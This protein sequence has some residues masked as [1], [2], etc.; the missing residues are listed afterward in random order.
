[1]AL[2]QPNYNLEE[3]R[4]IHISQGRPEKIAMQPNEASCIESYLKRDDV[5]FE[6]GSGWSTLHFSK[7][8]DRFYSVEHNQGW[9]N[10]VNKQLK[11]GHIFNTKLF[12]IPQLP[13]VDGW[14]DIYYDKNLDEKAKE[15][16]L[17]YT[18][19]CPVK[20]LHHNLGTLDEVKEKNGK[21]YWE[22]RG[23]GEWHQY[24]DYINSIEQAHDMLL[25][26]GKNKYKFDKV[27]V[28]G[29]CRVFCAY[30]AL[31]FIDENS[32]VFMHDFVYRPWYQTILKW[33]KVVEI[34][35]TLVVLRRK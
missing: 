33:Y 27:L 23:G 31:E 25:N 18:P 35:D 7:F 29:R 16:L 28:D 11:E 8:V 5:M 9:S 15:L 17:H 21:C 12:T 24:I 4:K 22:P 6:Y 14:E 3:A 26:T 34:I 30:K 20:E 10:I 2:I 13:Q 1:M 19:E 32:I